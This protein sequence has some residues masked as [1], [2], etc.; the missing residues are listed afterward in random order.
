MSGRKSQ[1]Q[2]LSKHK[3]GS[4]KTWREYACFD[5]RNKYGARE[6]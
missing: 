2:T 3:Q 1:V 5:L 4:L 6:K